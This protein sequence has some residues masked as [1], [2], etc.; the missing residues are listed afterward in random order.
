MNRGG[1][2]AETY[3]INKCTLKF[4]GSLAILFVDR[5]LFQ[6]INYI[7]I[8]TDYEYRPRNQRIQAR[9]AWKVSREISTSEK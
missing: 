4:N 3:G 9:Y 6:E 2:K 8:K 5:L 1:E 7:E